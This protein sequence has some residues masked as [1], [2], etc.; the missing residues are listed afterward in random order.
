MLYDFGTTTVTEFGCTSELHAVFTVD[1]YY[2]SQGI[3]IKPVYHTIP[4]TVSV[5]TTPSP[6]PAPGPANPVTTTP[7]STPT[8]TP[9]TN[10]GAIAGGIVGGLSVVGAL[11]F[12]VVFLILRNRRKK[13]DTASAAAAGHG[14]PTVHDYKPPP[15]RSQQ[16]QQQY[17]VPEQHP[18]MQPGNT[19]SFYQPAALPPKHEY[20]NVQAQ[21][22]G[23]AR[24]PE[25]E[26]PSPSLSPAPQYTPPVPS[27]GSRPSGYPPPQQYQRVPVPDHVAEVGGVPRP[28]HPHVGGQAHELA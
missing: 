19:A 2:T 21:P 15:P 18:L 7:S 22:V 26:L 27:Q 8:P 1:P 24:P 20:A 28:Y 9:K 23:H 4:I 25:T 16:Q 13:P 3:T 12:G 14:M 5:T 17:P 10:V 6:V 11:I